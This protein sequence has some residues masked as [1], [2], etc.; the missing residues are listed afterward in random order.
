MYYYILN[1]GLRDGEVLDFQYKEAYVELAAKRAFKHIAEPSTRF[2]D[3]GAEPTAVITVGVQPEHRAEVHTAVCALS[4]YMN[5]DY[6]AVLDITEG[7]GKL[8]G[9]VYDRMNKWGE[10]DAKYFRI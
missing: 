5:Q 1:V 10:F 8:L 2:T 4:E 6:I 9:H 7:K 3:A